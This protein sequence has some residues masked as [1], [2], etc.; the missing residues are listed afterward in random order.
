[1]QRCIGVKA[2]LVPAAPAIHVPDQFGKLPRVTICREFRHSDQIIKSEHSGTD[3]D[4]ELGKTMP[5]Q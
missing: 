2:A 4:P 1:M 3:P 5:P